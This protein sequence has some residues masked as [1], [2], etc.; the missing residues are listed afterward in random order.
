MKIA[1]LSDIHG[2]MEAFTA[3][4]ADCKAM[5]IS[6]YVNL[7]DMIGYGPD[8]QKVLDRIR[9]EGIP[10]VLG[11]HELGI[12]HKKD[13]RWFNPTSRKS[14]SITE[15]LLAPDGVAFIETLPRWIELHGGYY[16]HGFPP[17]SI[18]TYL[19]EK[20]EN[21]LTR[22]FKSN[23]HPRVF[24]GHTH[25]LEIVSWDGRQVEKDRL[26]K[27]RFVLNKRKYIT[28][29][30]SIGQPRD[31]NNTAKY[32]IWD[33]D[34][35]VLEVRFIPYDIETTAAKIRRRGFPDQYATRLF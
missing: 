5:G 11:N 2:N 6:R 26:T 25:D 9:E 32:L 34:E 13:R 7:G 20:S 14:L 4:L 15:N 17:S 27:G 28:T 12:I 22:W 18:K 8:P 1:V 33:P 21:M 30:G 23:G 10:S 31:G 16:I 29:A 24:V 3:V 35:Q 19:F